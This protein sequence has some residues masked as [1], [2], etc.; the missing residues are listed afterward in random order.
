MMK[1]IPLLFILFSFFILKVTGE[2][3]PNFVWILSED[4]SVHFY[5]SYNPG[6]AKTPA[7]DSMAKSGLLFE[8][9]FSCAPVC[10][11]ARSTLITSCF[12]PRIGTQFHRRFKMANMPEGLKFFPY[13]LQKAGYYTTNNSKTDYNAISEPQGWNNGKNGH[14]RNRP[15]GA[16]FF[17]KF[18]FTGSHESSLHKD[19]T[20]PQHKPEDVKLFPFYP[21]TLTFRQTHAT[22]LDRMVDND[23]YVKKILD[24]LSED[25][26]LEST[27]VFY[28]G[29][30]G[31]V[32]PRS[33]GYLYETGL[34]VPLVVRVPEKF[35]HLVDA[36]RGTKVKGFVEFVDFGPTLL[37]LAGIELPKGIDGK[38]FLGQGITMTEVNKRDEAFGYADRF[39]EKYELCRTLR[40]GNFKYKR[41]YEGYLPDSLYNQYRYRQNA[42]KEWQ[43]LW[44]EGKLNE[45]Q[46][47]FFEAKAPEELFDLNTDPFETKNL[48]L[49]PAYTDKL[50]E[51]RQLLAKRLKAMP[52]LSFYP[53]HFLTRE[54]NFKNPTAFGQ[55]K[56]EEI[57]RLI[58]IA[59]LALLPF[60]QA[61]EKI[62]LSLQSQNVWER[63]WALTAASNFGKKAATLIDSVKPLLE[64]IEI[65]NRVRA[66]EFLAIHGVDPVEIINKALQESQNDLE[67]LSILNTVVFLQ[68]FHNCKFPKMIIKSKNEWIRDP[69]K[70]LQ[71]E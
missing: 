38:P 37:N 51:L 48:A 29:D 71:W 49:D 53:E 41:N 60:E 65:I 58:D 20:H 25:G 35:K 33:K 14:W 10:S 34:Q 66:A 22:Y 13:Y 69:L 47:S 26:L 1:S 30:H 55:T 16:P 54:E 40:K 23:N 3:K 36:E 4:N 63:Y 6:G 32:M 8:H 7:I 62:K 19:V 46:K 44:K 57:A 27:F 52:D 42:C 45:L 21:D 68:D 70:Y 15:E 17:A 43:Q 24:E 9:A 64:D 31:G 61:S 11:V 39:D 50:L 12:A 67:I 2:D 5:D 59:D 28:F 56:K 18:T